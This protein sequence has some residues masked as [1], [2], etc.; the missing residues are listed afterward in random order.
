MM[1]DLLTLTGLMFLK[2]SMGAK[3]AKILK[4]TGTSYYNSLLINCNILFITIKKSEATR[5]RIQ[6]DLNAEFTQ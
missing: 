4:G 1:A 5:L 2:F 6:Y 3:L